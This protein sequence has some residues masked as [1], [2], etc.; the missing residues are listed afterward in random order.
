MDKGSVKRYLPYI[1]Q[2]IRHG[3]QDLGVKTLPDL[4]SARKTGQLRFELRSAA[5]Q[6]EGGVHNLY[7]YERK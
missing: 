6:R 2:G 4:R 7:S 3:M 5:A 1:V